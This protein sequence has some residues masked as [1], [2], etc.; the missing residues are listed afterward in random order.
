MSTKIRKVE[1]HRLTIVSKVN[2]RTGEYAV[3]MCIKYFTP[4]IS[5]I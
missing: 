3:S 2:L 1:Q 5:E 4:K